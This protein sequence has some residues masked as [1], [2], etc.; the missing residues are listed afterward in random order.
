VIQASLE[1]LGLHLRASR[2][3]EELARHGISVSENQVEEVKID[4]VKTPD[5]I[6]R[7]MAE[8]LL[9]DLSRTIRPPGTHGH[10][11]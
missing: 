1:R 11:R 7:R 10:R 3:V 9:A 8:P 2:V 6:R 5:P 4:L